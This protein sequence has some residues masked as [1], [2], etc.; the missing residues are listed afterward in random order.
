M[1][2]ME[3]R[4][5]KK[6]PDGREQTFVCDLIYRDG[7]ALIIRYESKGN[8]RAF[9]SMSE[10]YYWA[11][12]NYLIYRMF[13]EGVLV[14]HRFDVCKDVT[15]GPDSV[16][17]TDLYLDFFL[18]PQGE[19]QVHDEDEVAEAIESGLLTDEDQAIIVR[20]RALLEAEH[21]RVVAEAA[22]VRAQASG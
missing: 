14:G 3:I 17:W 9:A 4:E 18:T 8:L 11:G 15:L 12:R 2:P 16:E 21:Q 6:K 5:I 10:G 20:T 1:R 13:R 7:D 19:W 22:L